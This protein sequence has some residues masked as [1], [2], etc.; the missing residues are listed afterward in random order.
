MHPTTNVVPTLEPPMM[1]PFLW[2][3]A[4]FLVF[5]VALLLVRVRL[6]KCRAALEQA[7]LAI[8]D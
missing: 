2:A 4:S 8:Q 1:R 7:Y 5:Y 3:W 6:E